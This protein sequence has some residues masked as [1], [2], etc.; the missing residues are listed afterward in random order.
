MY[1]IPPYLL[2]YTPEFNVLSYT[3]DGVLSLE[4]YQWG[5]CIMTQHIPV[6]PWVHHCKD[7]RPSPTKIRWHIQL[8]HSPFHFFK[9]TWPTDTS[10][11]LILCEI[12][13]GTVFIKKNQRF[14]CS[15]CIFQKCILHKYRRMLGIICNHFV[16]I[17]N[18]F[19]IVVSFYFNKTASLFVFS[20]MPFWTIYKKMACGH[21]HRH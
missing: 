3:S 1:Y 17:W 4:M 21:R 10:L 19:A 5:V 9:P 12:F 20:K 6:E 15:T 7:Q 14:L 18:H 16:I 2:V 8:Q 11:Y 13:C